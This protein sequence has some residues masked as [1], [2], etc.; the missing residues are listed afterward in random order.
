M[1]YFD[2]AATTFPKPECVYEAMDQFYRGN[3]A[4]AARG[5]YSASISVNQIVSETR[6]RI[7]R[8]LH[9]PAKQVVFTPTATLALNIIIQGLL[10]NNG[11]TVY[12][13][14]LEHNAVTRVLHHFEKKGAANVIQLSLS[15]DLHYDINAI[16][17]QFSERRPDILIMTHASNVCGLVTPVEEISV[18]AKKFGAVVVIDMAQSAGLVPCNVGLETIDFAVFA[19]HKTLYGPT[20]ISGF[21]M[22]PSISLTPVLFGG[23]GFESANQDMP[24][25]LPER[26]EM[27]TMNSMAIAGLNASLKWIEEVG[28]DTIQKKEEENRQKLIDLLSEYSFVH[29]VGNDSD[30]EHVGV[31]SVLLEGLSSDS[32]GSIFDRLGIAVRTGLQCAPLAHRF[33]GTYPAGTVR[34][35]VGYFTTESDF[36]ELKHALTQIAEDI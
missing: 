23:T 14:P 33:L 7:K 11:K 15:K 21:V 10:Q 18:V 29:I 1:A 4:S 30:N 25:S 19:G 5:E 27:G 2:N 32:C 36:E 16:R 20:G 22:N 34:F 12:I 3:G 26:F 6:E 8:V 35:S 31:V 28:I 13:T 9:C 24:Q 17:K